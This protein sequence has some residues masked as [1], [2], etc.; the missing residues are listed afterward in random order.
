M[1]V[2]R[3]LLSAAW[4]GLV[5]A[6]LIGSH[7]VARRASSADADKAN[8]Q[9]EAVAEAPQLLHDRPALPLATTPPKIDPDQAMLDILSL[10]AAQEDSLD[11]EADAEFADALRRVIAEKHGEPTLLPAAA[12]E[13]VSK[14]QKSPPPAGSAEALRIASE[15]FEAQAAEL[16]AR[17]AYEEADAARQTAATLRME[18]RKLTR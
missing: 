1:Q 11:P 9:P 12:I 15:H 18:A 4:L 6:I 8:S 16:E 14:T 7:L 3:W 10:R 2:Q 5:P 13:A 17:Q